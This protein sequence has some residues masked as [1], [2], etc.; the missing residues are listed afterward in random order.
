MDYFNGDFNKENIMVYS[1]VV[2]EA[3][4]TMQKKPRLPVYHFAAFR[5]KYKE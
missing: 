5:G 4:V 1:R 3:I 2:G